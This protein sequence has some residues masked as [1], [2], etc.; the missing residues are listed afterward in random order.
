MNDKNDFFD[1]PKS[2]A[3]KRSVK[4]KKGGCLSTF[5]WMLVFVS[6]AVIAFLVLVDVTNSGGK[7]KRVIAG[8][9]KLERPEPPAPQERV[10]EKIVKVPVEKIVEKEVEKIVEVEVKPPMP[11]SYVAW[12]KIDTAKLW[13]EIPVETE[14][15]TTQGDTA[16]KERER[17]ESYRIKMTVE[18]TIPKPNQS[19]KELASI[20]EN[21]PSILNDFIPLVETAEV[22]PFYHKLYELKTERIQQKVTRIDQLLSRHNLY[23]CETV[24]QVTH[25]ETKNKVLLVQSEMDVVSDGSDGDRMPVLDDYIS[26]SQFYQPFTSYGW[27]KRTSTPNPLLER[28]ETK[29][30]E[31]EKE[32]AIPGLTIERNRFLKAN[33]DQ[34]K[35]EV[36]DMKARSYLIA[37]FDPFIVIPLS[38]LGRRDENEFGP[39][40]GDYAVVIYEDKLY[41]AIAGDAGPSWKFGEGS[42]RMAKT[43]NEKAS[44]YNRPVSDLKVTYLVFP[45]SA[46]ETKGPP[47]LEKWHQRCSA[48]LDGIGGIGEGY[49]LHQWEDLIAKKQAERKALEEAEAEAAAKAKEE[50]EAKAKEAEASEEDTPATDPTPAGE[51]GKP[52]E[53]TAEAEGGADENTDGG[54]PE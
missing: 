52:A 19:A 36:A 39:A 14:M 9:L 40:I 18:L 10:V 46:D 24:L 12:Q 6:A 13:S 4:R 1:T 2:N 34:L 3:G 21:L 49:E 44:A 48:L 31:Y 43:L 15:V 7:I 42:L 53:D 17:E 32:F 23:D 30:A 47:D 51:A 50:A 5:I 28:W 29:L 45:G 33:I 11:S 26:M 27:S 25:P 38:F 8:A 35:P 20:N 41:P 16:V 22:S 37:E 54:A